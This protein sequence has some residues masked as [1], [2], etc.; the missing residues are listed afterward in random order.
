MMLRTLIPAAALALIAAGASTFA[1]AA[2]GAAI[3]Q[4]QCAGCHTLAPPAVQSVADRLALAGPSLHY[5]ADK[6][7]PDW[8]AGWL[9][10]PTR[11]HPA[12]VVFA[13]HVRPGPEGDEIDEAT[14]DAHPALSAED[15]TAVADH[16]M[17]LSTKADLLAADY[18]PGKVSKRM[19]ML[20]FGKFKG[21]VA[22]HSDEEGYGG[23]SGPELYTA[24]DRLRPDYIVSYILDPQAWEPVS[25]MPDQHLKPADAHKLADYLK[26]IAEDSP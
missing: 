19:G 9:Q 5:A 3:A 12:G 24:W 23:A 1:L 20:N 7:R 17:T 2:N 8:L 15:A 6:Y 16:L 22:C 10:D 21:C 18:A 11:L 4:A 14:F 26:V 25:L 13:D